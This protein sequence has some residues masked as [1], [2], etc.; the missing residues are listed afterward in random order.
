MDV[1]GVRGAARAGACVDSISGRGEG[2]RRG[3]SGGVVV[4]G[5][6]FEFGFVALRRT[7]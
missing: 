1:T 7:E 2:R 6:Y 4:I 3:V 5:N